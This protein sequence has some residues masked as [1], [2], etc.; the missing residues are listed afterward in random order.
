MPSDRRFK[1]L[2]FLIFAPFALQLTY[3]NLYFQRCGLSDGEIGT[4]SAVGSLVGVI[5]PLLWGT[6][7]DRT[8]QRRRVLLA[9]AA[10]IAILFPAH[11]LA[12]SVLALA[13]LV[14]LLSLCRAPINPIADALCLDALKARGERADDEYGQVRLWGSLG[15][16]IVAALFP[17]VLAPEE[18]SDPL[19][20][21]APVFVGFGLLAALLVLR[22][23]T[24]PEPPALTA[25]FDERAGDV[26]AVL[27]IP[28]FKRLTALLFLS[29]VSNHCYYLFLSLYL[30]DIGVADRAKGLYW[31]VAVLAE[32]VLMAFGPAL[33]RRIGVRRMI[34]L[35]FLG[36]TLRLLAYSFRLPPLAA[37]LVFQPLHAF[38]F[39]SLHLGT[40]AFLSR[41]VP[42]R[43]QATAQALYTGL[44]SG[45]GGVLGG[46][47]AGYV[48]DHAA[49]LPLLAGRDGLYASFWVSAWLQAAV[50][51]AAWRSLREP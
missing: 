8:G 7:A 12:R 14:A 38:A 47:L 21:L 27:A 9:L 3:L 2:Y 51:L 46:L 30:D 26:R 44:A 19:A 5:A 37:L 20:R 41:T 31:A 15:F 33:L 39:A 43:L 16:M 4:L 49:Q 17:L 10:G 23:A 48:S 6:I 13:P 45:L 22:V 34:L 29:W 40:V 42:S 1:Q 11:W 28:Q 24:L 18:A 35:G 25:V 50:V 32:V 36:R